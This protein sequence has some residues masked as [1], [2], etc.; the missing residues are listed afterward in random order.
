M[1]NYVDYLILD[2]YSKGFSINKIVDDVFRYS[3]KHFPKNSTFSSFSISND[4]G[5]TRL[6]CSLYV[7]RTILN[8]NRSLGLSSK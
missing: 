3:K 1:D 2:M 7:S 4:K 8:R 5:Y 6:D